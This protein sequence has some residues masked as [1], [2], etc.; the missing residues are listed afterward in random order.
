MALTVTISPKSIAF[1]KEIIPIEITSSDYATTP[2][3]AEVI[4][5][6]L[7]WLQ[8]KTDTQSFDLKFDGDNYTFTFKDSPSASDLTEIQTYGTLS[9]SEQA[10]FPQMVEAALLSQIAIYNE[11]YISQYPHANA[12][13]HI[14]LLNK[15]QKAVASGIDSIS[16]YVTTEGVDPVKNSDL[17]IYTKLL[18][19]TAQRDGDY[20]EV[21]EQELPVNDSDGS[22]LFYLNEAL[23]AELFENNNVPNLPSLTTATAFFDKQTIRA[24]RLLYGQKYGSTVSDMAMVQA[25]V[26]LGGKTKLTPSYTFSESNP[27]ILH[28]FTKHT[29]ITP[30]QPLYTCIYAPIPGPLA[31]NP[32]T[33]FRIRGTAYFDDGTNATETTYDFYNIQGRK[34]IIPS[35]IPLLFPSF[36][37]SPTYAGKTIVKWQVKVT[38]Q[39]FATVYNKTFDVECHNDYTKYFIFLNSLGGLDTVKFSALNEQSFR[40]NKEEVDRILE[41]GYDKKHGD[42]F[43]TSKEM[44]RSF[45]IESDVFKEFSQVKELEE[46]ILSSYVAE[47]D[48]D[49][50]SY[51]PVSEDNRSIK[52]GDRSDSSFVL[53]WDYNVNYKEHSY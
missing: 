41:Y 43:A 34:V 2:G 13:T 53:E 49:E 47:V 50:N 14:E 9:T 28:N 22:A 20:T 37:T 7:S 29:P 10:L 36:F 16:N 12:P 45:K 42:T 51:I 1:S 8:A 40:V 33:M 17:K 39:L 27:T 4:R 44:I 52:I 18:I 25:S 32:S 35:S 3:V 11:W 19:E 31:L 30:M 23:H 48:V 26:I 38:N 21:I 24:Y 15:E 46:L 6:P 5:I